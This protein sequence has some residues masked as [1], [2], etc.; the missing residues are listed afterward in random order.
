MQACSCF[1]SLEPFDGNGGAGGH[2]GYP[3]QFGR[4]MIILCER[5]HKVMYGAAGLFASHRLADD[6]WIWYLAEKPNRAGS[7]HSFKVIKT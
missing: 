2:F 1:K 5:A 7:L 3:S 6:V 4:L